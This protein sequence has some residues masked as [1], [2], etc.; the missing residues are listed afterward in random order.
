MKKSF[1][2]SFLSLLILLTGFYLPGCQATESSGFLGPEHGLQASVGGVG[3]YVA[4][5][6]SC[7]GIRSYTIS[8][9]I[10]DS[11][12]FYGHSIALRVFTG[13]P[14]N[15]VGCDCDSLAY[16]AILSF[17]INQVSNAG[18]KK[19]V[20]PFQTENLQPDNLGGWLG[21]RNFDDPPGTPTFQTH[22][23]CD[24]QD[25]SRVVY[26]DLQPEFPTGYDLG[27][28]IIEVKGICIVDNLE[29]TQTDGNGGNGGNGSGGNGGGG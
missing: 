25:S 19:L 12:E 24:V 1:F 27:N 15:P 3:N 7:S 18:T 9:E 10:L 2:F 23:F 17:P 6:D 22:E 20:P 21:H 11:S 8:Y 28:A 14:I 16:C 5:S 29:D 13:P 4:D 26:F